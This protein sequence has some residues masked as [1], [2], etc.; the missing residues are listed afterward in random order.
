M[1]SKGSLKLIR[2]LNSSI[3]LDLLKEK[4]PLSKYELSKYT[5]LSAPTVSNI[6]ND[7][8][9]LGFVKEI[10]IGESIGGRPPLMLDLNLEGGFVIG[11]DIGNDDITS[12]V[13]NFLGNVVAKSITPM[14]TGEDQF[15]IFNKIITTISDSI[16][17]SEKDRALFFGMGI[18]ISGEVNSSKGMIN[19]ASR[20]KWRNVPLKSII[21]NSFQIPT[22]IDENVRLLSFAEN[23]Y[24]AGK[25]HNNIVCLRVGEDIGAGIIINGELYGGSSGNAGVNVNHMIIEPNGIDCECGNKGC[26]QTLVSSTAIVSRA[27]ELSKNNKTILS[28]YL[29]N[30]A[31][32]L[33]VKK[34]SEGAKAGDAICRKVMEDTGRYLA[35]AISNIITCIDPELIIIGGGIAQSGD[36]LLEPIKKYI[37]NC[38]KLANPL[39]RVVPSM[40]G[41]DAYAIGAATLVLHQIFSAP[42]KFISRQPAKSN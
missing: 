18:G 20:L 37:K 19:Y 8:K 40:L 38:S 27:L 22:Y 34:I 26:L 14:N 25:K 35:I 1:K 3:I 33:S 41:I 5:N 39:L 36:I 31:G 2:E 15:V 42:K 16:K 13:V 32:G 10:G 7:L 23:W 6:I 9:E 17:K 11:V 30:D 24:G 21:E 4:A 29:N 12:I 28:E